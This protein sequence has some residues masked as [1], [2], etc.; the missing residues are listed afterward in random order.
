MAAPVIFIWGLSP[1]V[2]RPNGIRGLSHGRGLEMKS[3]EAEAV[4]DIVYSF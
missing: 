1:R 4:L 2:H 3:P